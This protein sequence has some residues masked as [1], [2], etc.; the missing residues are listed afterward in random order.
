MTN[1]Q[2][3]VFKV[4]Q[5]F[6]QLCEENELQYWLCGGTL[7]GAIRHQ[8]FIPWDDDVDVEMPLDDYKK[9]LTLAGSLPEGFL[10]HNRSNDPSYPFLFTK[11]CNTAIPCRSHSLRAPLGVNID[12]FPLIPA[13]PLSPRTK[14][15]FSAIR[16]LEYVLRAKASWR[17]YIPNHL[18]AR[19][20]YHV[21]KILP[22]STL[23]WMRHFAIRQ[24]YDPNGDTIC[25]I[26]GT[27]HAHQE[28]SPR[29]WY[30]GSV[31]CRFEGLVGQACAGWDAWLKQHYGDYMTLPPPEKRVSHHETYLSAQDD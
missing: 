10:F 1:Q 27:Y 29:S 22:T 20:V 3:D 6:I 21:L 4:L 25:S 19:V 28:F 8:G 12:I 24:I 11:L 26:G 13:R 2:E 5:V 7:L 17:E 9:L 16:E 14:T 30:S 18:T 15:A 31:P 23:L